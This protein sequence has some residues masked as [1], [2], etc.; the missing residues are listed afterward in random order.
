MKLP[1]HISLTIAHNPH[2]V[3]YESV[4]DYLARD[5]VD[6]SPEDR[7]E[8]VRTGEV[9]EIHWYP[10]TPIGFCCIAAATLERAL[11]IANEGR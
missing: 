6:V 3:Y 4:E 10:D 5:H 8:M 2:A 11:E 7:A 9:W 1:K